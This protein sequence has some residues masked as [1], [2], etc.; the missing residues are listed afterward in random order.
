MDRPVTVSQSKAVVIIVGAAFSGPINTK[1]KR[2]SNRKAE[3]A[4]GLA[5]LLRVCQTLAAAPSV[6][7]PYHHQLLAEA[8]ETKGLNECCI[9]TEFREGDSTSAAGVLSITAWPGP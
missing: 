1:Q 9:T 4:L 2:L 8:G 7:D 5:E 6:A 3:E